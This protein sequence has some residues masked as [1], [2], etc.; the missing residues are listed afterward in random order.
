MEGVHFTSL[1]D[2]ADTDKDPVLVLT[3][4]PD[5]LAETTDFLAEIIDFLAEFMIQNH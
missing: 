4:E 3:Q 5:F 1:G 2:L